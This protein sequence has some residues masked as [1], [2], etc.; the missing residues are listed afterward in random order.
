MD[1]FAENA[2]RWMTSEAGLQQLKT[3][4][5]QARRMSDDLDKARELKPEDLFAPITV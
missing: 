1:D 2:Q 4:I 5:E 3:A